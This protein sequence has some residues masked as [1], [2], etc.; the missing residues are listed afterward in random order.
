MN[1][2]VMIDIETMGH[3]PNSAI[4]SIGAVRFNI[5]TGETV[6]SFYTKIDLQSCLDAG[7]EVTA[8]TIEFWMKQNDE[9]RL[10]L[11]K[12]DRESLR[13]ALV[14]LYNFTEES[15]Y[16]WG[17]A[18]SFDCVILTNAYRKLNLNPKWSFYRERDFRTISQLNPLVIDRHP[19]NKNTHN[20]LSDCYRQIKILCDVLNQ[21]KI[22]DDESNSIR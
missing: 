16:V 10:E 13:S 15:D 1:N 12:D 2:N 14:R 5:E 8:S 4:V 6:N 3:T 22:N 18:P 21:L 7:L 20:A 9:V 11:F 19:K 17:N